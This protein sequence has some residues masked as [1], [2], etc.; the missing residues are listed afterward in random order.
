AA[1]LAG[2][3]AFGGTAAL[4]GAAALGGK[5]L[6]GTAALDGNAGLAGCAAAG[7]GIDHAPQH[8]KPNKRQRGELMKQRG[9]QT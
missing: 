7:R 3:A 5:G 2:A 1:A 8:K 4:H 6:L 9:E